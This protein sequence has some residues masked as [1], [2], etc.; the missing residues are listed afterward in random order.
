MVILGAGVELGEGVTIPEGSRMIATDE[1]DWGGDDG[2]DSDETGEGMSE[3]GPKAFVY[4][5]DNVDD[6]ESVTSENFA[7]D[8]WGEVYFTE[9]DDTSDESGDEESDQEFEDFEN[10]S[11]EETTG[12]EHDDVKNF[13]REVIDSIARGL[14][15]GV[16]SDN[17]VLEINGS[18]HAWNITLSEV[19]QC[20]LYAVL[21][22]N[23][24]L[25]DSKV[26]AAQ[27]LPTINKNINTLQLLPTINK[28]I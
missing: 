6:E 21:T 1:D 10:E 7:Q 26:S 8:T 9:D 22:A 2:N 23:T 19:N 14:E 11:E 12:G 15:Q 27:L 17:L 3:W 13:R 16:A 4:K 18:K 20:V 5:D 28:N 25:T 24:D